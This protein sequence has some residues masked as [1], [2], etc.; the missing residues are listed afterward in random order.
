MHA[1]W[2]GSCARILQCQGPNCSQL[3]SK[4]WF[5]VAAFLEALPYAISCAVPST[6]SLKCAALLVSALPAAQ[7][8]AGRQKGE[9]RER[10]PELRPEGQGDGHAD[11]FDE[12]VRI[13]PKKCS[14][15]FFG[16]HLRWH[17]CPQT[18]RTIAGQQA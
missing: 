13:I 15:V 4:T 2:S 1:C 7:V 10:S 8:G 6:A 18:S 3:L 9:V 5:S 17:R 14:L 16:S 12:Q 11:G